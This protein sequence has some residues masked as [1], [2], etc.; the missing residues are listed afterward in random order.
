MGKKR[1]NSCIYTCGKFGKGFREIL[2]TENPYLY[3]YGRYPTLIT[4]DDLPEDYLK[5]HSRAIWYMDGYLRTSGVKDIKYRW[6]R[7]NHLFKDDY[8]YL[9]YDSPIKAVTNEYGFD[10]YS[11]YD[12]CICGNDIPEIILWIEHYSG[13]DTT[14]VRNGIEAKRIWLRDNK[15]NFYNE[16]IGEDRDIFEMWLEKGYIHTPEMS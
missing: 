4:A 6:A 3:S 13:I 9:S 10:D 11:G 5:I 12:L 15:E 8:I 16:H 7:E 2:D 14:E 1:F